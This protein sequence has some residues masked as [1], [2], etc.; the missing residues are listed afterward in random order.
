MDVVIT[1][2]DI[3]ITATSE[4]VAP[5]QD[6]ALDLILLDATK[7]QL[8]RTT[9]S[10]VRATITD[11]IIGPERSYL[12]V[13]LA[14]AFPLS[15]ADEY[16]GLRDEKDK[17]IG[18]MRTLMGIDRDSRKLIDEELARRYFVPCVQ[19][20]INLT[21][22]AGNVTWEVETDKGRRKFIV[23]NMRESLFTIGPNR[24][25]LTDKDGVRYEFPDVNQL[26]M[27]SAG[28][29]VAQRAVALLNRTSTPS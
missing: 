3:N 27:P 28:G 16:I 24:Y 9:G 26:E 20:I 2:T 1:N 14:R 25:L 22:E 15:R 6:A 8:F 21:E 11:P 12:Q 18:M 19:K 4:A 5:T 13:R 29:R 23:Q 7:V 10:A 17:D